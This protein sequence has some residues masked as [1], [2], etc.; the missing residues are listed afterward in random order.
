MQHITRPTIIHTPAFPSL[1]NHDRRHTREERCRVVRD[2]GGQLLGA[3]RTYDG[4]LVGVLTHQRVQPG[5]LFDGVGAGAA[6]E[7]HLLGLPAAHLHR[8]EGVG[9]GLLVA[10][11][12]QMDGGAA[13]QLALL[14]AAEIVLTRVRGQALG[15]KVVQM[16]YLLCAVDLPDGHLDLL[17]GACL[18]PL[19]SD[20]VADDVADEAKRAALVLSHSH[21]IDE[22]TDGV[23]G[24]L[25]AA[26][27]RREALG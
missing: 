16:L 12:G 24:E 1:R 6:V 2:V 15:A 21:H 10:E 11:E 8:R 26:G 13:L 9:E 20:Q 4:E 14:D 18:V 25:D 19:R 7:G 23:V 3:A 17:Q 5:G 22:A 27:Q